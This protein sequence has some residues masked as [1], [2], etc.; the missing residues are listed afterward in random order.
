MK[1]VC[2]S[3]KRIL[4]SILQELPGR[5]DDF[6]QRRTTVQV[7]DLIINLSFSQNLYLLCQH[8]G[9]GA[10]LLLWTKKW[11]CWCKYLNFSVL[12]INFDSNQTTILGG[13]EADAH[14]FP[15]AVFVNLTATAEGVN[16]RCGGTLVTDR[17]SDT[18]NCMAVCHE[19]IVSWTHYV[20]IKLCH[21]HIVPRTY[22]VMNTLCDEHI[23]WWT[24]YVMKTF[25]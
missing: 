9:G 2:L 5:C 14:E 13:T 15:W 20:M 6:D 11:L 17:W 24:H 21:E 7:K 25:F 4:R 10:G 23:V 22:C 16:T 19:H 3:V 8:W 18:F 1:N 12:L